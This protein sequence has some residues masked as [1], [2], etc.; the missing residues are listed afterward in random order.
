VRPLS[1]DHHKLARAVEELASSLAAQGQ[2]HQ[3][4]A[5]YAQ[6]EQIY[7]INAAPDAPLVAASMAR[8][9]WAQQHAGELEQAKTN[10]ELV[11]AKLRGFDAYPLMEVTEGALA[12]M[13]QTAGRYAEA[14]SAIDRALQ[15][16][17]RLLTPGSDETGGLQLAGID[18]SALERLMPAERL[19]QDS[20]GDWLPDLLEAAVGLS[21]TTRDSDADG[22]SDAHEDHDRDGISNTHEFALNVNP[23]KVVA[24]YGGIDPELF[25]FQQPDNRRITGRAVSSP[26]LGSAW[27]VPTAG[28]SLYF[29]PLTTIQRTEALSRGW[30]LLCRGELY[31]GIAVAHVDLG[32]EGPRFDLNFARATQGVD[33]HLNTSAV[34]LQTIRRTIS[35]TA[36][37]PLTELEYDPTTKR[38]I[39]LI[40]GVVQSTEA[41]SGHRQFLEDRGLVFGSVNLSDTERLGEAAFNL[42]MFAIR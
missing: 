35:A 3:A 37:W 4:A 14:R 41:Y 23:T 1:S 29:K 26:E 38:A 6:A 24:H 8:L 15:M 2:W 33:L 7:R 30:R 27:T 32:P 10:Y 9:A 42:A 5:Q 22:I 12:T 25:A 16:R 40:D 11:L 18:A 21:P 13:H 28:T 34:P 39:L 19:D 20:D 17:A 36:R 31:R